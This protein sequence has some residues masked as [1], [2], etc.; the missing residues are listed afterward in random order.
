MLKP[1]VNRIFLQTLKETSLSQNIFLSLGMVIER[2]YLSFGSI[3]TH[4]YM[5]SEEPTLIKISS[6]TYPAILF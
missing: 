3:I 1:D 2:I 6:I 4:S 5:N